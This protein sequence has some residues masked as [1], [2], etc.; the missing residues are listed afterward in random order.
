MDRKLCCREGEASSSAAQPADQEG[1]LKQTTGQVALSSAAQPAST[2]KKLPM[3]SDEPRASAGQPAQASPANAEQLAKTWGVWEC[4]TACFNQFLGR[5]GGVWDVAPACTSCSSAEQPALTSSWAGSELEIRRAEQPDASMGVV[6]AGVASRRPVFIPPVDFF[7]PQPQ[8]W[9]QCACA[10]QCMRCVYDGASLCEGCVPSAPG[11][12]RLD[13][14][15]DCEPG[16]C[17]IPLSDATNSCDEGAT[18]RDARPARL[19]TTDDSRNHD[20]DWTFHLDD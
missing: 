6:Y 11:R 20:D 10:N 18:T 8:E 13:F 9:T 17:G 1:P 4:W 15:C 16:C 19:A 14:D 5:T 3:T 12:Q 7:V 2:K